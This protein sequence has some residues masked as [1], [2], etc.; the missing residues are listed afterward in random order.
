MRAIRG[1]LERVNMTQKAAEAFAHRLQ[2]AVDAHPLAPPTPHGRQ[3]WLRDRLQ[4]V[5]GVNVGKNAVNKWVQGLSIPRADTLA[6]LAR[7]LAVDEVWLTLGRTPV[8]TP[9]VASMPAQSVVLLVAGLLEMDGHRVTFPGDDEHGVSLWVNLQN[10]R[11]AVTVVPGQ[12]RS[13]EVSFLVPE[14]VADRCRVLGVVKS[15]ADHTA[16][17]DLLDL[18]DASR[19]RFGGYSTITVQ[20]RKEHKYRI[21]GLKPLAKPVKSW[22]DLAPA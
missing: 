19:E 3:T 16:C 13:A 11:V 14:P 1:V 12:R 15:R 10:R 2:T 20:V 4:K 21:P 5:G 22:G 18:T 6:A 8:E 17:V 9:Q 7:V